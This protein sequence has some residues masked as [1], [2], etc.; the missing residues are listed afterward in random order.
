MIGERKLPR[1][2]GERTVRNPYAG[3][4]HGT[5]LNVLPSY[6]TALFWLDGTVITEGE[7]KYFKDKKGSRNFLITGYDFTGNGLPYKSAATIS[8]PAADAVLIAADVNNF[9][10]AGDGTPNQIPVVSMF[11]D[12]DYE[13]KLFCRHFAQIVDENGVETQEP[14]VLDIVLYNTVKVGG[15]LIN[16]QNYYSVPVEDIATSVWLSPLGNDNTG[17]GTKANPYRSFDKIKTTTKATVYLKTGSYNT[18]SSVSF[19]G[20][21]EL[22]LKSLGLVSCVLF[23]GATTMSDSRGTTFEGIIVDGEQTIIYNYKKIIFKRCKLLKTNGATFLAN[24]TGSSDLSFIDCVLNFVLTGSP[25]THNS[26]GI[27]LIISGCA[28][29]LGTH[30]N[31]TRVLGSIS[32]TNNKLTATELKLYPVCINTKVTGNTITGFNERQVLTLIAPNDANITGL[33]VTHNTIY[34]NT[35]STFSSYIGSSSTESGYNS[36]NGAVIKYNKVINSNISTLSRGIIVCGGIDN[37]VKYNYISVASGGAIL[38]KAGGRHYTTTTPHV[39]YNIIKHNPSVVSLES[40]YVRGA[41]GVIVSNNTVIDFGGTGSRVFNCDD[42]GNLFDNSMICVNNLIKL[43]ANTS[44]YL[45]GNNITSRNNTINRNGFLLDQAIGASDFETNVGISTAGIPD[46]KIEYAELIG[47]GI[48]LSQSCV[49]PKLIVH[50]NQGVTW[51]NG[52]VLI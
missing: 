15:E 49:I 21:T 9:L 4:P 7:N 31:N 29:K 22:T 11:Q 42:D 8:A 34:A 2:A 5:L 43:G 19:S 13:H 30:N 46:A 1:F 37:E 48:G 35:T 45:N 44:K 3:F 17:N 52:A 16:C 38:I 41:Y 39:A 18:T 12:V 24:Q 32:I 27:N 28:G 25:I 14:R 51:Q 20:A 47:D 6:S 40:I 50:Q 26:T 23:A 36:I 33:V 10:Y